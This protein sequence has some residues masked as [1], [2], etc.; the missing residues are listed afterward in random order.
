MFYHYFRVFNWFSCVFGLKKPFLFLYGETN[1]INYWNKLWSIAVIASL[2]ALDFI[3]I[4]VTTDFN[5]KRNLQQISDTNDLIFN[6]IIILLNLNGEKIYVKLYE[7]MNNIF[8]QVKLSDFNQKMIALKSYA[9]LFLP[10]ATLV[11][12]ILMELYVPE[13]PQFALL[14]KVP[15][16]LSILHLVVH[17]LL[18][19]AVLRLLNH[20]LLN[21]NGN[22]AD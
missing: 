9:W 21:A 12:S 22:S 16:Y 8:K 10:T 7:I 18:I 4:N 2:I 1:K 19:L 13:S 5:I 11:N 6:I 17:L 14:I 15:C 3:T 20:K